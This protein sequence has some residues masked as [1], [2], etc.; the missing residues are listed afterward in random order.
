LI[1]DHTILLKPHFASFDTTKRSHI[2]VGQFSRVLKQLSLMPEEAQFDLIARAYADNNTLQDINYVKF[3]ED[4]DTK[5]K[6]AMGIVPENT[7]A[8]F[9][10]PAVTAFSQDEFKEMDALKPRFLEASINVL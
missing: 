2:S 4:V 10:K 5:F 8:C 7:P 3:C 9:T 6:A 1:K